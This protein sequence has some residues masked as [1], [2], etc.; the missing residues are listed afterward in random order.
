MKNRITPEMI[1]ETY[2]FRPKSEAICTAPLSRNDSSAEIRIM[3]NGFILAS[4]ATMI[5]VKPR[6]PAVEVE[7][8]WLTAETARKPAKPHS[9]P[10]RAMVRT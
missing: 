2:S 3:T 9:A 6:P 5:A 8:V 7:S 10:D 1:C 4:H